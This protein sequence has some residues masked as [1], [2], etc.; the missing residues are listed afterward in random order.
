MGARVCVI[1]LRN[2]FEFVSGGYDHL[3]VRSALCAALGRTL[4]LIEIINRLILSLY[5]NRVSRS[6]GK[7]NGRLQADVT[8]AEVKSRAAR[9]TRLALAAAAGRSRRVDGGGRVGLCAG[10]GHPRHERLPRDQ[11]RAPR[12][13]RAEDVAAAGVR[14]ERAAPR[15]RAPPAAAPPAALPA[16]PAALLPARVPA[17]VRRLRRAVPAAAAGAELGLA[18]RRALPGRRAAARAARA[19]ARAARL[20]AVRACA[21][22]TRH[23]VPVAGPRAAPASE[24]VQQTVLKHARDCD[25]PDGGARGRPGVHDARVLLAG[26]LEEREAVQGEI[27]ASESHTRP[28]WGEAVSL[29]LSWLRQSVRKIRKPQDPQKN[30]YW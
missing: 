28:H 15:R 21:A 13:L 19:R 27:Q 18:R 26:V 16:L 23:A 5:F 22:A 9:R 25:T 2:G 20:P 24:T 10:V 4:Q 11:S 6:R 8:R 14:R 3:R 29:P 1:I 30:A 17:R 7:S 12:V